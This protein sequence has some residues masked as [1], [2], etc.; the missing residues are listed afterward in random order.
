MDLKQTYNKIAQDWHKD[1]ADDTWWI[2]SMEAFLARLPKNSLVLDVGCAGGIKARF[3]MERGMRVIGID[4]AEKFI[5]IAKHENPEGDFR[6]LDMMNIG[7][8]SERFD[9]I[10]AQASLL[11]IPK[12]HIPLVMAGF[13]TVL[14][15]GGRLAIAVKERRPHQPEEQMV[16]EDDYGYTYERFFRY[17]SE[18]EMRD[19]YAEA[20]ILCQECHRIDAGKTRWL[21][22]VGIK[23]T[24]N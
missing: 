6:V 15:P 20:G 22:L 5:D 18:D 16:V 2:A 17:F 1:H 8:M 4:I 9:A 14:K 12:Q 11:H 7:S 13:S 10:C 3:M 19:A 23:K 21:H 24:N